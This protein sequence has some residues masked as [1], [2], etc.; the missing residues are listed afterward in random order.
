M[1]F[2]LDTPPNTFANAIAQI[3]AN[4]ATYETLA[5]SSFEE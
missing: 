2:P 3:W 1:L 5:R 4:R